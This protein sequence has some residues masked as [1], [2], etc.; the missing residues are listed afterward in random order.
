MKLHNNN[1]SKSN[2]I[3]RII[4]IVLENYN[5]CKRYNYDTYF[6]QGP[7]PLVVNLSDS[8]VEH[9]SG[10]LPIRYHQFAVDAT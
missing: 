3:L 10:H 8:E 1:Y 4:I 5:M 7:H 6:L 2:A 9:L